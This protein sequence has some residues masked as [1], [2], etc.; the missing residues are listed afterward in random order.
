M[1]NTANPTRLQK[2]L[3]A[4][5]IA[6]RRKAEEMITAGRVSV[7]GIIAKPGQRAVDGYDTIEVDGKTIACKEKRVYIA[8]N[9]P[10]GYLTTVRDDRG[11]RTVMEL[12]RDAGI[13]LYPAGR[14]DMN[15]EGLLVL[16]NDGRFANALMHPSNGK[17]KVYEVVIRGDAGKTV[18]LLKK[19]MM[20]DGY[21]VRAADVSLLSKTDDGGKLKITLSEGRNRQIRKMCEALGAHVVSLKRLSVGNIDLGSL[22]SGKWRHL[23][24]EE[25]EGVYSLKCNQEV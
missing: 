4:H 5:G 17:H 25:I 16:T 15:S 7:N 23:T 2:I 13:D 12:V 10:R 19:P 18:S 22:K 6:S 1:E 20:I 24:E 21:E 3:S 9:K 14:L 8:L 11:R